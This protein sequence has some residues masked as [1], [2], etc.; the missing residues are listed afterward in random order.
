MAVAFSV[1]SWN[2]EHFGSDLAGGPDPETVLSFLAE[3]DPDIIGIYE[4]SSS[5]VI[6]P[7]ME[8]FLD[9]TFHITEGSQTQ[10]ILVGTRKG[11][12]AFVT[13]KTTFKSR[14]STLRPG[15]LL[16][17]QAEGAFYPILFLHLKSLPD[18]KGLWFHDDMMRRALRFRSVLNE[19]A[20]RRANY[21]FVGD[22]NIMGLDYPYTAHDITADGEIDEFDRW[23]RYQDLRLH[24]KSPPH[25]WWNGTGSSYPPADLD[26]V[27][28][29]EHLKFT[30]FDGAEV[31]VR[32]WTKLETDSEQTEWI[33]TRSDHVLLYFEVKEV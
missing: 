18:P 23:T 21:I 29:A 5:R 24:S 8:T 3:Q 12:P 20:G 27:G 9:H 31:D 10:E 2:I 19:A 28:A 30:D 1:A 32:G 11:L 7:I 15:V 16:T 6:G 33:Q 26:H 13:Q 25:T 17:V 14:Q 22:L 4:V